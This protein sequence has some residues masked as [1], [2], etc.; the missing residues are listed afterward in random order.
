MSDSTRAPLLLL[1]LA[2]AAWLGYL[3]GS[4]QNDVPAVTEPLVADTPQP[5]A[6][7]A[8]EA[9]PPDPATLASNE[10]AA[11]IERIQG[12]TE[13]R[14]NV[15]INNEREAILSRLEAP[16]DDPDIGPLYA[17]A[18]AYYNEVMA[19]DGRALLLQAEYL[20]RADQP[21]EAIDTLLL[22]ATVPESMAQL[23]TIHLLRDD[24]LQALYDSG[25]ET[26]EWLTL[27]GYL[28]G[29]LASDTHNDR[30]RLL[31]AQ[32]QAGAGDPEAALATLAE[33]G[34]QGV[35]EFEIED[36]RERLTS[37]DQPPVEFRREGNSLI[38]TASVAAE[39]V[40]L[41][42]DTGATTT[43]LSISTLR[44]L[45]ARPLNRRT[46]VQTA[47][48]RISAD[49]YRLPEIIIGNRRFRDHTVLGL[50]NPPAQWDGLLGMDLLQALNVDLLPVEPS[51]PETGADNSG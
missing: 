36:L 18:V 23:D 49:L 10:V 43:A 51:A 47:G 2:L 14:D 41:L 17:R 19:P 38:A 29:L 5:V 11:L 20:V 31:L 28:A 40:Q 48:G 30:L 25:A 46:L 8:A 3:V 42:V 4:S 21:R 16:L 13:L 35:T 32:A 15:L 34:T 26:G 7:S 1:S 39:P 27:S 12:L 9:P 37:A 45:G 6:E 44:Q 24:L 33:T 50:D 22:A